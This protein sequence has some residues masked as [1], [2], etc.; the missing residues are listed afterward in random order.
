MN[1]NEAIARFIT[2]EMVL[3]KSY[4]NGHSIPDMQECQTSKKGKT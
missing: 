1:E 4:R 3:D 2:D